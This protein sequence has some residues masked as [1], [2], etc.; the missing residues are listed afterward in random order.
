MLVMSSSVAANGVSSAARLQLK[1]RGRRAQVERHAKRRRHPPV[2]Q[3][4]ELAAPILASEG[5]LA[6]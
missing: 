6:V 3:T 2:R 1:G 5:G 4:D